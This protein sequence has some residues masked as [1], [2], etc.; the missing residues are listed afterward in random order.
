M[1]QNVSICK[2]A[3]LFLEVLIINYMLHK[4]DWEN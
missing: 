3:N 1:V 4:E 2:S